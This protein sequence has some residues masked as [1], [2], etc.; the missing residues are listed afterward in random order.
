MLLMSMSKLQDNYNPS[1]VGMITALQ[2]LKKA[3]DNGE[4]VENNFMAR[5]RSIAMYFIKNADAIAKYNKGIDSNTAKQELLNDIN[6]RASVNVAK[7][8]NA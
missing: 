2:N 3:Y 4:H 5:Q 7:L 1:V 8:Q 6:A